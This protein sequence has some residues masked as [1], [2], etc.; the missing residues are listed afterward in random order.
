[1]TCLEGIWLT[2][3]FAGDRGAKKA[4]NRGEPVAR[5]PQGGNLNEEG[6]DQREGT[7]DPVE[8]HVPIG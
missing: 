8:K 2:G 6:A 1:M 5:N 7:M 4:V 3:S